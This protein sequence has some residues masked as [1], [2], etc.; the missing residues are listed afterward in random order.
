MSLL[1]PIS[2]DSNVGAKFTDDDKYLELE[3]EIEQNFNDVS[4]AEV[5][6][7]FV[8]KRSEEILIEHSKDMKVLSYWLYAQWKFNG[9]VGFFEAFHTFASLL[10]RYNKELYPSKEKRKVKI[11]EWIDKVFEKPLEENIKQFSK[12]QLSA[13]VKTFSLLEEGLGITLEENVI[14]LKPAYMEAKRLLEEIHR[15]EENQLKEAAA[16]KE[17][18]EKRY[19]EDKKLQAVRAQKQEEDAKIISQFQIKIGIDDVKESDTDE[20][21]LDHEDI[22]EHTSVLLTIS[23]TLFVSSPREYLPFNLLFSYAGI[24]LEEIL[25]NKEIKTDKLL[26]SQEVITVIRDSLDST[27]TLQQLRA[28]QEQLLEYPSWLEGYYIAAR[29]MHRLDRA[30]VAQK[31]E[32]LLYRY[33]DREEKCIG[34]STSEGVSLVPVQLET[35]AKQKILGLRGEGDS[36]VDYKKVYQEALALKVKENAQNALEFLEK[37]YNDASS[38][39]A[40]YKWRLVMVDFLL[41]VGDKRLALALLLALEEQIEIYKLDVWQPNLAIQT[42]DLLLKPMMMQ[43][44]GEE[45]QERIYKKLSILDLQKVLKL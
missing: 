38:V 13:L 15:K 19:K 41:E 21:V 23:K 35:W 7:N 5:N 6:W 30:D 16:F 8:I 22:M 44:L 3:L 10:N 39:E 26:P 18:Q 20:K 2:T 40:Q 33:I 25:N 31:I 17:E 42:Y 12:E 36:D 11:L 43:Q 28:L 14:F 32:E 29:M 27:I 24:M 45:N 9:W 34:F 37:H 1:E 4:Q